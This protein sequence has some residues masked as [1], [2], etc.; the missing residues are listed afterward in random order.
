MTIDCQ[1]RKDFKHNQPITM[2]GGAGIEIPMINAQI[3][4][5]DS[6]E[7]SN[8]GETANEGEIS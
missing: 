5:S 4:N 1:I 2:R 7:T 6:D 8:E 3:K